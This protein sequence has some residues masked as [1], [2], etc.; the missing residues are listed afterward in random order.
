M[1]APDVWTF[2]VALSFAGAD[3]DKARAIAEA[4]REQK[5]TV[6]YDEW[7]K[8]HIW[9]SDLVVLLREIYLKARFCV[10]LISRSY[11]SGS[12]PKHEL[13]IMLERE[14]LQ[15]AGS[16]LPVHLDNTEAPGLSKT[17]A[18]VDYSTEGPEGIAA[19]IARRLRDSSTAS[20][21]VEHWL[22]KDLHAVAPH[23][24][25]THV[26]HLPSE[27]FSVGVPELISLVRN[28]R[29][30]ASAAMRARLASEL[31]IYL[32]WRYEKNL[33]IPYGAWR[34]GNR[35]FLS[36]LPSLNAPQ[37][38]LEFE[39]SEGQKEL[40]LV[41][42]WLADDQRYGQL[43]YWEWQ[44]AVRGLTAD[45]SDLDL[46]REVAILILE[47]KG[48]EFGFPIVPVGNAPEKLCN[49]LHQEP[50]DDYLDWGRDPRLV[51]NSISP[52]VA[53][54]HRP[55][56]VGVLVF[57]LLGPWSAAAFRALHEAMSVM[58]PK[59]HRLKIVSQGTV[60]VCIFLSATPESDRT[61]PDDYPFETDHARVAIDRTYA[62][63]ARMVAATRQ[64]PIPSPN[65]TSALPSLTPL[66]ASLFTQ[67]VK[68][69]GDTE[70]VEAADATDLRFYDALWIKL[71]QSLYAERIGL[72]STPC[73]F[74]FGDVVT[75]DDI[76]RYL[77]LKENS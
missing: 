2:D 10:P 8:A 62:T 14:V 29:Q 55:S 76:H 32:N 4:L 1:R 41:G 56:G 48:A 22:I 67:A 52:W 49:W 75:L 7:F 44:P 27:S 71:H 68:G 65:K 33:G 9:G 38:T 3:R 45:R 74:N 31:V 59:R 21:D 69:L 61:I 54:H 5:F 72:T 53:V 58:L 36:T 30:H 47:K 42:E 6:F 15:T 16:L 35:F 43:Q 40:Y 66:Y 25:S 18:F 12:Y 26:R 24:L 73:R 13:S 34:D 64:L 51:H 50:P 17:I 63:I 11:V 23:F 39:F 46:H 20:N 37:R 70:Y 28:P 57:S 19:L 77:H 60:R